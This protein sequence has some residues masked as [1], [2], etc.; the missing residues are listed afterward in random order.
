VPFIENTVQGWMTE[1]SGR[2]G[3]HFGKGPLSHHIGNR[4]IQEAEAYFCFT[5]FPSYFPILDQ[6][7]QLLGNELGYLLEGDLK[8]SYDAEIGKIE[9]EQL[10][11][12]I[13]K[14][15]KIF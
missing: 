6:V 9:N 2:S 12:W 14:H 15:I 10:D 1:T 4:R 8:N 3:A 7:Y 11:I 5:R 13:S